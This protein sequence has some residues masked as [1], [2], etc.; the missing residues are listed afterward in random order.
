[1]DDQN[2]LDHLQQQLN[3]L[4]SQR[5]ELELV[6]AVNPPFTPTI[7]ATPYLTR[8]KM[9]TVALYNGST[10]ADEHLENYQ[11]HMLIQNWYWRLMPGMMDSFKL[12][13]DAF[14]MAFLNAKTGIKETSYL[15]RI[16]QGEHEPLKGYLDRFDKPIM[17]VKNCSDETLIQAFREGVKDKKLLWAIAYDVPPTF[18]HLWGIA[19]KHAEAEE[20]IK[21]R[22]STVGE[23]SRPTRKSKP[24]KDGASQAEAAIEK[25][26]CKAE[27]T[28]EPKTSAGRFRQYTPLVA[29]VEHVMNQISRR[30]LLRMPRQSEQTVHYG[31]DTCENLVIRPLPQQVGPIEP[32]RS[33]H[34]L[35]RERVTEPTSGNPSTLSIP[36][37]GEWPKV[38][39]QATGEATLET[40]GS[41]ADILF[42][43]AFTRLKIDRAI[44][45]HIQTPLYG[46]VGECVQAAG[47]I[48]LPITIGHGPEKATQMVEFLVVNKPL[49]YNVILGRL[50]LNVL[51]AAVS[52]YHLAIK[53]LLQTKSGFSE[54]TKRGL[55][56]AMSKAVNKMCHRVPQQAVVT[57]IFKINEINTRNGEIKPL[58]GLNPRMSEEETEA[59]PV[60][61]L[62]PYHLD[63][64]YSLEY[65]AF[66]PY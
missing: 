35:L 53:F 56:N 65:R 50:T 44:L 10:D 21:G 16:K 58:S 26:T 64:E 13:S 14:S 12:L 37:L 5:Y 66:T 42:M 52:T 30:E 51:K 46:F 57:T 20:Y 41:S 49:V 60:E 22:N 2:K 15:F 23:T 47:L 40:L 11:A 39:L 18:A 6:G 7:M 36:F 8:F 55:G 54:G 63:P 24:K 43:D 17:Q 38:I 3:F 31:T 45:A 27:A 25:A 4:M 61:D 33:D 62:V 32:A 59:Q 1:M 9:P 19:Q 28:P 29:T 48:C 34:T